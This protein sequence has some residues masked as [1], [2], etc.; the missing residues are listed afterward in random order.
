[1]CFP[2]KTLSW[3]LAQP[4]EQAEE[5]R[6]P[7]VCKRSPK[8]HPPKSFCFPRARDQQ[9]IPVSWGQVG[10][11][12]WRLELPIPTA[13]GAQGIWDGA[14]EVTQVPPAPCVLQEPQFDPKWGGLA[15]S[16]LCQV[17]VVHPKNLVPKSLCSPK[18]EKVRNP[19][20]S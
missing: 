18:S 15:A 3:G 7:Q 8:I 2:K 14:G 4:R 1:M 5:P 13:Q 20:R 16:A 11:G 9:H 10:M 17:F 19:S 6:T 12:T